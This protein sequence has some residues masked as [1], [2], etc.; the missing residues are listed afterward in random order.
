MQPRSMTRS[1]EKTAS[2]HP[3]PAPR[4]NWRDGPPPRRRPIAHTSKY[5]GRLAGGVGPACII[6][7]SRR[8]YSDAGKVV[9]MAISERWLD[10][11]RPGATRAR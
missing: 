6:Y 1:L 3:A 7:T 2:D 8:Q 9:A 4:T 5:V 10:L 11:D